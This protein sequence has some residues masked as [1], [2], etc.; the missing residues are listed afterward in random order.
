MK[1]P[2]KYFFL[3]SFRETAFGPYCNV[4][5]V[6]K[7]VYRHICKV[8]KIENPD[9]FIPAQQKRWMNKVFCMI[10]GYEKIQY[11]LIRVPHPTAGDFSMASVPWM[12]GGNTDL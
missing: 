11:L 6:L 3:C 5:R 8:G 10:N 1:K 7:L 12:P 9:G 4:V 2:K